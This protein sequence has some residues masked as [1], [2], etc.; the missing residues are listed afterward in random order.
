MTP[1]AA[2]EVTG[3]TDT[4]GITIPDPFSLPLKAN[5]IYGRRRKT[6]ANQ[7]GIAASAR[8][9]SF[10]SF[11]LKKKPKAKNWSRK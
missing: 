2:I 5:E 9:S 4:Q 1:P 7:W 6:L 11:T 3:V 10:K 8:A